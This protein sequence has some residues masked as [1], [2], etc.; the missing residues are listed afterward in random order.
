MKWKKALSLLLSIA[1][2]LC[3]LPTSAFAMQVFVKVQVSGKTIKLDVEPSDTIENVK[4]KIQDKEGIPPDQQRIIFAGNQLEDNRTLADYN[5]QKESTLHLVLRWTNA[6]LTSDASGNASGTLTITLEIPKK[7]PTAADFTYVAPTDLVYSGSEKSATV[8]IAEGVTGMGDITVKYYS[9]AARTTEAT[10]KNVGTYYVG[11]TVAGGDNY[12]AST[13]VLYGDGW[14]FEITKSTPTA[15]AAPTKASATKNSIT[16]NAASGCEYSKDGANWQSGTEF[17]GLNPGTEYTFY[18]RV[19]A[20]A[21]TNASTAS[22]ASFSTEADTYAMKITLKIE[23]E[24]IVNAPTAKTGLTY[25]GSAQALINA[26]SAEGGTMYYAVTTTNTEPTNESLYTTDI[27]ARTDAG[28]YYVWYKAIGDAYHTDSDAACVTATIAAP[29]YYD[30][31][32][33]ST[34]AAET[35]TIPVSGEDETVNVKVEVKDDTATVKEADVDKV[36]SAEEVGTVTVDVSTLKEDVTGVVIPSALLEKVADAVADEEN[37]AD[38]LEVKLPAGSVA[39]DADALATITEQAD[40]KDLTLHLDDVKVTELT[41]AQQEGVSDLEIEVVLDAYLTSGGK[42]ISDFNGGSAT[43]KIPYTLK[44]GQI[45]QGLVVWY[46]AADGTR[47]QVPASY[48][49]KNVVFTVPH[50]SN[51]VIAYDAE[52]AAACSKDAACPISAFDDADPT[53]WY[54]DGVHFALENGMMNGVGDGKFDPDG[55]TTR[56]MIVTILYRLE[57]EPVIRSG[58]P[59]SDVKESDWYA[60]AVSWAE[61]KGIVNGFEDGTFRPNAPITREQLAAILYRYEQ[62]KGGGF[63][64]AWMFLLDYPDAAEISSWADEAMHWCVMHEIIKG[65][66]GR[67]VPGGNATRAEAATMLMRYLSA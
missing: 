65:K 38:G 64:G 4:A 31:P 25:N 62:S 39:F 9:D 55:T 10:P 29:V 14:T 67:L 45:A 36:L 18:Q 61:S 54:H 57:G 58:M 42:R 63:V 59:F 1:L 21:N 12:N 46:V 5:I 56:A 23:D 34:P 53:A 26:G 17:T 30:V 43:V 51:Y 52:K 41:S 49:G 16:L 66:D 60:K 35:V 11:A 47:T 7:T 6:T 19:K 2:V 22:S 15:P 37:T 32:T 40:G 20:T 8:A 44:D 48:D 27:P 13:A 24:P 28:T 50:F 3:L 33:P